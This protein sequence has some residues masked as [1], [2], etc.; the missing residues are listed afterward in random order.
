MQC[1]LQIRYVEIIEQAA[2]T[3]HWAEFEINWVRNL[4]F[5]SN[6]SIINPS[7]DSIPMIFH[8]ND[9]YSWGIL[10]LNPQ[11]AWFLRNKLEKIVK[12]LAKI[13]V[14]F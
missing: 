14:D 1:F 8:H 7:P 11:K 4:R 9:Q 5:L 12:G 6:V 13:R 3:G 2:E 10:Q